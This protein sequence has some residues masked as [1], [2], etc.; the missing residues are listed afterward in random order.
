[1]EWLNE[2]YPK[3]CKLDDYGMYGREFPP[4][5]IE[6]VHAHWIRTGDVYTKPDVIVKHKNDIVN[7]R[8]DIRLTVLTPEEAERRAE[9]QSVPSEPQPV[10]QSVPSDPQPVQLD[11]ANKEALKVLAEKG[12]EKAADFMMS[13]AGGD[14]ARMRSM[15]G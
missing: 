12:P 11:A 14:Y 2:H 15:Y 7:F 8:D 13:M 5:V 6:Y 9:S 10:P 3:A 4:E 1:M